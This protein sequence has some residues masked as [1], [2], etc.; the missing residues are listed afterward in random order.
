MSVSVSERGGRCF[1]A[2]ASPDPVVKAERE[3]AW[4]GRQ[5]AENGPGGGARALGGREG[6]RRPPAGSPAPSA[7]P[8]G[9]GSSGERWR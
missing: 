2:P 4:H 3:A 9:R 5:K 6:E 8:A 1:A 7:A